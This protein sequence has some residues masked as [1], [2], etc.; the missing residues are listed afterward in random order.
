MRYLFCIKSR[1]TKLSRVYSPPIPYLEQTNGYVIITSSRAAR[2]R[3]PS[4]S[5]CCISKHAVNRLAEY[6][7]VG[8]LR[9]LQRRVAV[10]T[11]HRA[12]Q[13]IRI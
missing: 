4:A 10:I 7:A 1:V 13:S 3:I 8:T 11:S 5:D 6:S 12:C 2:I 9:V